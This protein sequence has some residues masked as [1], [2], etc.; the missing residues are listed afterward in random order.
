MVSALIGLLPFL[1][2]AKAYFILSQPILET[3]RLDPIVNPGDVS[4]HVHSIAGGSN[5]D[6]SMTFASSRASKC[7]TAPVTV[8]KSNYWI[9]QMYYY[10]PADQ[11]YQAIPVA[12]MN[13]YYLPRAGKD[14]IV[15][16][17][18]DGLRMLSGTPNR[19]DFDPSDPYDKAISYVCLDYSGGHSNDP[20]WAQ[21]NN[22]F[23]HNCPQGMR[24]QVNFPPCWDGIN[25]DSDDHQ[26]HMAWPSGGV[27]GGEC[28]TSHPVH[29]VSLFYEFIYEVQNFP[30]NNGSDP[31]WVFANGDASGYGLH[32][33][34]INGWPELI[35]GTNVLQQAIEQC[36]DNDGVGG[37]LKNCP[38]FV[39]YLDYG[40]ASACTPEN[41]LERGC[42]FWSLNPCFTWE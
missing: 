24:A 19:R 7:T 10:N 2:S 33:D 9:P 5:F 39:P 23:A 35:N 37:E 29:L 6:K 13:A 17:F 32:A 26:S 20:A 30:F 22:F 25:L 21:R 18:P 4:S 31:T 1:S 28:P 41:P 34:F 27:D 36:N 42:R 3:T 14:G 16:A 15:K 8:D 11:S 38:P 40:A 12:Y